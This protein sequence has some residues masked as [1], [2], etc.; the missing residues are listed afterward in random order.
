M[1]ASLSFHYNTLHIAYFHRQ[2]PGGASLVGFGGGMRST[3]LLQ[4]YT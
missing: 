3:E 2:S 1:T 4:I